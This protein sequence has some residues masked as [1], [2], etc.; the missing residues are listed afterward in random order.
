MNSVKITS[1]DGTVFEDFSRG[2]RGREKNTVSFWVGKGSFTAM[3]ANNFIG[4]YAIRDTANGS[5]SRYSDVLK[6]R[7]KEYPA[8]IVIHLCS[9][10]KASPISFKVNLL[11]WCKLPDEKIGIVISGVKNN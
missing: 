5:G 6:E 1:E 4:N 8:E 10:T 3:T 9:K 2:P 7:I 11:K